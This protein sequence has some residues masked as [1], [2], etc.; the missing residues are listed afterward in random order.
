MKQLGGKQQ[1][2]NLCSVLLSPASHH[3]LSPS[4]TWGS[5]A[6]LSLLLDF[7]TLDAHFCR[8]FKADYFASL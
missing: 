5:H 1:K 3:L 2:L 8:V 6:S 7:T 4:I